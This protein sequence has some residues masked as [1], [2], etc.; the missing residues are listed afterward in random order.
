MDDQPEQEAAYEF[1]GPDE[2]G[3]VRLKMPNLDP[4]HSGDSYSVNI[5]CDKE[6]IARAMRQW[7]DSIDLNEAALDPQE[8]Q[9]ISHQPGLPLHEGDD[10]PNP[11]PDNADADIPGDPG[12]T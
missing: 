6:A 2:H 4:D 3:F 8:T 5:G 10:S 12:R 1:T 7:L 11:L 9:D